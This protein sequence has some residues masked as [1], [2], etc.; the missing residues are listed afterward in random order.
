MSQLTATLAPRPTA[1]T[2]DRGDH[3]EVEA[4]H[5]VD[6]PLRVAQRLA[7]VL[8]IVVVTDEPGNVPTRA[9]GGSGTGQHDRTCVAVT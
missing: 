1:G 4:Q 3:G 7:P 8:G 6:Q 9:E 2:V 5:L